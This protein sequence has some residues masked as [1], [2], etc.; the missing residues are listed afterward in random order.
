MPWNFGVEH[1]VL[2]IGLLVL[3]LYCLQALFPAK[4]KG[5]VYYL[6]ILY[7]GFGS[8]PAVFLAAEVLPT[9]QP[10]FT[11]YLVSSWLLFVVIWLCCV[12]PSVCLAEFAMR[13][14]FVKMDGKMP[15]IF[16]LPSE[17]IWG[18]IVPVVEERPAD[19]PLR[20]ASFCLGMFAPLFWY[21]TFIHTWE[22]RN[23]IIS[24]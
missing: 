8:V 19:S 2:W 5:D 13:G 3:F 9:P 23:Y 20:F 15:K 4:N 14:G 17:I 16:G 22:I 7:A 6:Q 24:W 11:G 18:R 21:G 1:L 12:L 10:L